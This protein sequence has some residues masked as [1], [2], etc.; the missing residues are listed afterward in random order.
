MVEMHVLFTGSVSLTVRQLIG[1]QSFLDLFKQR[2]LYVVVIHGRQNSVSALHVYLRMRREEQHYS[3]VDHVMWQRACDGGDNADGG[4]REA[5][6][7]G[8]VP[9]GFREQWPG[10]KGDVQG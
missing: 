10:A 5:P 6:E 1:S 8:E 7:A 3:V 4:T 2:G 9:R